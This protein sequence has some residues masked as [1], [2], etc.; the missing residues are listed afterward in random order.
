[1]SAL[2]DRDAHMKKLDEAI[3]DLHDAVM[4]ADPIDPAACF[5]CVE[6]ALKAVSRLLADIGRS[7]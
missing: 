4:A 2:F 7:S 3:D 5:L 6:R 1:V